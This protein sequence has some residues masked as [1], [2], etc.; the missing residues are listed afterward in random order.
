MRG[1]ATA[2]LIF[3]AIVGMSVTLVVLRPRLQKQQEEQL[4]RL[5][6]SRL[7]TIG[8][9]SATL[10]GTHRQPAAAA[11]SLVRCVEEFHPAQSTPLRFSIAPSWKGGAVTAT[12]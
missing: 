7:G 10:L 9:G 11:Q 2:I 5:C 6:A 12:P 3:I 1:V 4:E 8:G